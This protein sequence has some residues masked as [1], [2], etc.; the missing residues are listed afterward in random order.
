MLRYVSLYHLLKRLAVCEKRTALSMRVSFN[1]LSFRFIAHLSLLLMHRT[2]TAFLLLFLAKTAHAQPPQAAAATT[3]PTATTS[4][5]SVNVSVRGKRT[6]LSREI[7]D[8]YKGRVITVGSGG[9]VAGRETVYSLLD[10]GR[11]FSRKAGDKTTTFIGTQTAANTK[12]VFWSVEDRCA[13]KKTTYSKPGNLYRFVGWRKGSETYK[14]AWTPGAKDV[15]A[16][17]DKVYKAFI[18]MLPK[19]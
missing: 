16:N 17:F 14:V 12:R 15:P 7:P 8:R 11:L 5:K 1:R 9:G 3:S 4:T 19:K 6:T 13:I 2:A 10:D 18:G